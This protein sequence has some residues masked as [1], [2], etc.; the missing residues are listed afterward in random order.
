M[1]N[2]KLILI[3]LILLSFCSKQTLAEHFLG[4]E[5][6]YK[7]LG[8]D[9]YEI[10]LT[11]YRDC[12]GPTASSNSALIGVFD[13][14]NGTRIIISTLPLSSIDTIKQ[15][16]NGCLFLCLEKATYTQMIRLPNN[17]NSYTL[18]Y[19]AC[20]RVP[21]LTN[22][23]DSRNTGMTISIEITAAAASA[24][25]SSPTF[26]F[27]FP[28]VLGVNDTLSFDLSANDAEG[29]SL[30]YT[31]FTPFQGGSL[32]DPNPIPNPPPYS[33]VS[34]R[35]SF[36]AESPIP[37]SIN[38][39]YNALTGEFSIA[40]TTIGMYTMGFSILEYNSAGT[41]L[42]QT[43]K[44]YPLRVDINCPIDLSTK[45]ISED[46]LVSIFPNPSSN[47]INIETQYHETIQLE[48][49]S[50]ISQQLFETSFS[51]Q[52]EINLRPFPKGVYYIKLF[53]KERNNCI[54]KKIIKD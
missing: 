15:A 43:Y 45:N 10:T 50:S 33:S 54:V 26:N 3:S 27:D 19:Q 49:F 31:L 7:C 5:M 53:S 47:V 16:H 8:N 2:S 4:G 41:L 20:C 38:T 34:F 29:D 36:T 18:A 17:N 1:N 25:N 35:P 6:N 39:S 42:S 14:Q 46:F 21:F 9:I 28:V 32:V 13:T 48:L 52:I 30:V 23:I 51:D 44:D 24:C 11:T 12:N 37:S 22:L 40:P